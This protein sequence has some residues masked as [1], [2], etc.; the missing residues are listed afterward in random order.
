MHFRSLPFLALGVSLFLAGCVATT[1][2]PE[3]SGPQKGSLTRTYQLVD[4][5]GRM[6]GTLVL[7][8][9]GRAELRDADGRLIGVFS[10]DQGFT[11]EQRY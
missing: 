5:M 4:E 10:A 7:Q 6:S 2:T 11:P 9:M 1:P 8:P 3:E